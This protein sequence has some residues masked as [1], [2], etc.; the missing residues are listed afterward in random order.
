MGAHEEP[1]FGNYRKELTW[2]GRD[3]DIM[4]RRRQGG[5]HT[6]DGCMLDAREHK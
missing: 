2:Q 6:M 4:V 5:R 3:C 1:R